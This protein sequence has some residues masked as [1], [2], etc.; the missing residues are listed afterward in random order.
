M[1]RSTYW[2]PVTFHDD[3]GVTFKA[4]VDFEYDRH[5]HVVLND[6]KLT[7][8]NGQPVAHGWDLRIDPSEMCCERYDQIVAQI[9]QR[10][11]P[12]EDVVS[13]ARELAWANWRDCE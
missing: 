8:V 1:T 9:P 12:D 3:C 10:E 6:L 2:H 13:E 7:H 11:P 4:M 5:D